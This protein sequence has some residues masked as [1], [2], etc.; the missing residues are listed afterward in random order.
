MLCAY[1]NSIILV[2]GTITVA[3]PKAAAP[4]NAHKKVILKNCAPFTKWISR[5]NNTQVVDAHDIDVVIPMYNLSEY[6]NDYSKTLGFYGNFI[7]MYRL[8]KMV[9]LLILMWVMLI[10]HRLIIDYN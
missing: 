4:N 9:K 5:I 3:L 6:S 7:E 2:K 8:L 10:L 1:S